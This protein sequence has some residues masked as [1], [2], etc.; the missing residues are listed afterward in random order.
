MYSNNTK[1]ASFY[2]TVKKPLNNFINQNFNSTN[3]INLNKGSSINNT[4]N[5]IN[6]IS[7]SVELA[8]IT[9]NL[10]YPRFKT[11]N[12]D[13]LDNYIKTMAYN[14]NFESKKYIL[15]LNILLNELNKIQQN[16]IAK[17]V[18]HMDEI[19]PNANL[20]KRILVNNFDTSQMAFIEPDDFKL[21]I[22]ITQTTSTISNT[23]FSIMNNANS[24]NTNSDNVTSQSQKFAIKQNKNLEMSTYN[25]NPYGIV[26]ITN[27]QP[28]NSVRPFNYISKTNNNNLSKHSFI[29]NTNDM[30]YTDNMTNTT[31]QNGI[32]KQSSFMQNP[33][34][35]MANGGKRR[36]SNLDV[37]SSN[38]YVIIK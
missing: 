26:K 22:P 11:M 28:G 3:Q 1:V 18:I 37:G 7:D 24:Y 35:V 33:S 6:N 8:L 4:N 16:N 10:S 32:I 34:S 20:E 9:V 12:H 27:S 2:P 17:Q 13:E 21:N 30:S 29:D 31:N 23:S 38:N 14:N 5:N 25:G 15:S 19:K 36:S